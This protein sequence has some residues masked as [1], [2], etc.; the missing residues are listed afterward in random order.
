[1][2]PREVN[3]KV[4]VATRG[5]RQMV[6]RAVEN[7][8]AAIRTLA[9][10]IADTV[11]DAGDEAEEETRFGAALAEWTG[12][13]P[14]RLADRSRPP[15]LQYVREIAP[16]LSSTR[17]PD[18]LYKARSERGGVLPPDVVMELA[19]L[20]CSAL[21]EEL[22]VDPRDVYTEPVKDHP[23]APAPVPAPARTDEEA[24]AT[25]C[26][27]E[28]DDRIDAV[29]SRTTGR[30]LRERA[31]AAKEDVQTGRDLVVK[32]QYRDA[33]EVCASVGQDLDEAAELDARAAMNK[34][35]G[36]QEPPPGA[37]G[38]EPP[39]TAQA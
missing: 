20:I 2:S 32:G 26:L 38:T 24:E 12:T 29:L 27:D 6:E 13:I 23:A 39:P 8:A 37:A 15:T 11:A 3:R 31:K 21:F 10:E 4:Q 14:L 7:M 33:L 28:L 9:A 35:A 36:T 16:L 17:T 5:E 19:A 18:A 30:L 1:M 25:R 22:G 34:P